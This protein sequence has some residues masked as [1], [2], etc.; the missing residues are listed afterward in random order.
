[1]TVTLDYQGP[2]LVPAA[3]ATKLDDYHVHYFL[4]EDAT[5]YTGTT[6]P[7]PMGNPH[8]VHAAAL[9]QAFDNVAAGSHTATVLMTGANHISL[10]PPVTDK[11]SFTVQ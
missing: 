7:V 3:Q 10:N 5:P 8:I 11:V 2:T 1:V 4:D 9:Q 6:T